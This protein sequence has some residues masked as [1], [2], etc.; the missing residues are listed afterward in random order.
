MESKIKETCSCGAILEFEEQFNE[1]WESHTAR[2]QNNFHDVHARC[3]EKIMI[4]NDNNLPNINTI[5]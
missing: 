2:R 4:Y 5:I 3:R 1:S